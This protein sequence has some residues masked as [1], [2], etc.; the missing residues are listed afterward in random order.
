MVSNEPGGHL[1]NR[2]SALLL[3]GLLV[4]P[5]ACA[6][7]PEVSPEERAAKI[8]KK[9]KEADT[10]LTNNRARDAE[11]IYNWVLQQE[12]E[13]AQA[14][15][16]LA[17]V[18]SEAKQY[19][20]A[21]SLLQRSIAANGNDARAHA[22]LGY[23]QA[24]LDKPTEAAAAFGQAFTLAPDNARYG[25]E[26]GT[27]LN[28]AKQYAA[29]EPV[30]AKAGEVDPKVRYV[31]SQLGDAQRGQDKLDDALRSYMKS[32]TQYKSDKDA[33]AGAARIYEARGDTRRAV[34]HWSTYVRMDCCSKYSKTVARP[35]L[36]ELQKK[37]NSELQAEIAA[38]KPPTDEAG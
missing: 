11:E 28:K 18:R 35:K 21:I 37:E 32:L 6:G 38:T 20:Q 31:W 7:E 12:P 8:A 16:G 14:L 2:F 27:N 19:D 22:A 5:A 30:L 26:Q 3:A 33:H 29:A 25:L 9:L 36:E 17:Q 10:R 34:D 13:H 23:A 15:R 1:L 24:A 4:A